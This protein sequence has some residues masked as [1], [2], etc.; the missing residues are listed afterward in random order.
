MQLIDLLCRGA[1]ITVRESDQ[2]ISL[3]VNGICRDEARCETQ[4]KLS[5]TVQTGYECGISF[6]NYNGGIQVGD[7]IEAYVIEAIND[8]LDI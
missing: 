1:Q 2:I 3:W 4:T 6:D 8:K 7:K 5:S